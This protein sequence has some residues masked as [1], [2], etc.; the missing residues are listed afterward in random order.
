MSKKH[1]LLNTRI[2]NPWTLR[3]ISHFPPR[4]Y[5][6][7]HLIH[8]PQ[9]RR[10]ERGLPR[11][12]AANDTREF[13]LAGG[14][15]DVAEDRGR[16]AGIGGVGVGGIGPFE[17]A[18]GYADGFFVDVLDWWFAFYGVWLNFVGLEEFVETGY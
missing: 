16:G 17:C 12:D 13:A 3:H 6:P 9:K 10:D 2:H 5:F 1:I 4:H 14:E 8:I 18:G 7:L 11:A 15:V